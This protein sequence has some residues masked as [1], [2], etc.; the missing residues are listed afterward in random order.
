MQKWFGLVR[1]ICQYRYVIGVVGVGNCSVWISLENV[2]ERESGDACATS[3]PRAL[4]VF[5]LVQDVKR[6]RRKDREEGVAVTSGCS[7]RTENI[8]SPAALVFSWVVVP[9]IYRVAAVC[10]LFSRWYLCTFAV[11]RRYEYLDVR[12]SDPK[13]RSP[14]WR[15]L[16]YALDFDRFHC[17]EEEL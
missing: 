14:G 1:C 5:F 16:N 6:R 17:K 4:L 7:H 2:M 3:L 12:R 10:L 11:L 15:T 8:F 9:P 13:F